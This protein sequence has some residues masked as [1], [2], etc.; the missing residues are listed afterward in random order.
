ME[1][2]VDN[3]DEKESL[4]QLFLK[5]QTENG[6]IIQNKSNT[7]QIEQ[8]FV[9]PELGAPKK[10]IVSCENCSAKCSFIVSFLILLDPLGFAPIF[11]F[12]N[13]IP[14][15]IL[16]IA[17]GILTII[18]NIYICY[19]YTRGRVE[20]ER[21]EIKNIISIKALNCF[22]CSYKQLEMKHFHFY[23]GTICDNRDNESN[24]L[25]FRLFMIKD[26][27]NSPEIDL[28]SSNIKNAPIKLYEY[29]DYI[30]PNKAE[31]ILEKELNDLAGVSSDYKCPFNFN[32][33]EYMNL[34]PTQKEKRHQQLEKLNPKLFKNSHRN[35]YSKYMKFGENYFCYYIRAIN[36]DE[37]KGD[38]LRIDFIYSKNFDRL[39]IGL[40][41]NNEKTYKNTFEFQMNSIDNFILQ[42]IGYED[43]G[44]I[45]KVNLKNNESQQIYSLER[46]TKEELRGLAYL[47]NEKLKNNNKQI[48]DITEENPP[49]TPNLVS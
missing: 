4:N 22:G 7:N 44:Y 45:L 13:S 5:P 25:F 49:P 37:K 12:Y 14:L 6:Q 43:K 20:I 21:N 10:I 11:I 32:I 24:H 47:L 16:S 30:W 48:G 26:L 36:S 41:N 31:D 3:P 34:E 15:F 33:R 27:E 35:E 19:K 23:I 17:L 42:K 29:V 2:K 9:E 28:D 18:L 40:V 46:A 38:I 1:T 8:F 39:F